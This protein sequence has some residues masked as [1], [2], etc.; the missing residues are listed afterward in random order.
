[1][2]TPGQ[3]NA[4]PLQ[5]LEHFFEEI[6][7]VANQ[8]GESEGSSTL[9]TE[10]SVLDHPEDD[11]QFK[12]DLCVNLGSENDEHPAAYTG[13][14]RIVG[15]FAVSPKY[16]GDLRQ[17]ILVTG[18]S[19]LFGACREMIANFTARSSHGM[20]SLPSVSFIPP[21]KK[22]TA[23]KKITSKKVFKKKA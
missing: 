18:S 10:R 15:V 19:I 7:L 8:I 21:P 2:T 11:H 20:M 13:R 22:K 12:L 6:N 1:M 4:S 17:L 9:F 16:K 3:L 5:L 14:I 23:R